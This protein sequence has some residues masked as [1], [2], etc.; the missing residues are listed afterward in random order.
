MLAMRTYDI[1]RAMDYLAG[2]QDLAERRVVLIGEGLGGV[3]VLTAAAMDPRPAAVICVGTVPS[4]KLIVQ[5]QYYKARDYFWVAGALED[6]D[7]P[8]L[9]GLAAPKA[10][11][12]IDPVDGMLEPLDEPH[13]KQL[14]AWAR[15]V[16]QVLGSPEQLKTVRTTDRSVHETAQ[17]IARMLRTL[18]S[19]GSQ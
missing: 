15:G 6:F 8:D 7:L 3:W 9:I 1:I 16:Y 11:L 17:H 13:L 18:H 5:S 19:P 2:C 10:C 4:Y 12:L 14:S